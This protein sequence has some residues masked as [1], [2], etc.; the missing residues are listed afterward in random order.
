MF[1]QEKLQQAADAYALLRG[2]LLCGALSRWI[3]P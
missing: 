2:E 3:D 1:S